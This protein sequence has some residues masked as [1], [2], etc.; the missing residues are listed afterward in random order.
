MAGP[1]SETH[2]LTKPAG[3]FPRVVIRYLKSDGRRSSRLH[4]SHSA[5]FLTLP[6]SKRAFILTSP[7]Q[8]HKNLWVELEVRLFLLAWAIV[9]SLPAN[10]SCYEATP[11]PRKMSIP[12][13]AKA[14]AAARP[15]GGSGFAVRQSWDGLAFTLAMAEATACWTV[16]AYSSSFIACAAYSEPKRE[17][18]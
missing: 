15:A 8:E 7:P 13:K 3:A 9:L 14:T 4:F 5:T 1:L 11:K 2:C 12:G 10:R 6:L 18:L 17:N 16:S